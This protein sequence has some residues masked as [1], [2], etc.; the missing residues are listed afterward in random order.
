EDG[1]ET[2]G[3]VLDLTVNRRT[4][5]PLHDPGLRA[6]APAAAERILIHV[7]MGERVSFPI[8]R[9]RD[10]QRGGRGV[11]RGQ[12]GTGPEVV[13]IGVAAVIALRAEVTRCAIAHGEPA[14]AGADPNIQVLDIRVE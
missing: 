11:D 8:V 3:W 7:K 10:D 1:V 14:I 6:T 5:V 9:I 12:G 13:V 4:M 2:P